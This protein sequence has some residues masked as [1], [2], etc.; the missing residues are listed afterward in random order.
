MIQV[1]RL[2]RSTFVLNAEWIETVEA[3]PDT[4]ITMV[5]GK[6]F[7]VTE[8]VGEILSRVVE[9][10]NSVAFGR[11]TPWPDPAN[12]DYNREANRDP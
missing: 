2:N 7:V 6:K 4:V 11:K 3:T 12:P 1:T 5:N 10:K 9:Y 8:S